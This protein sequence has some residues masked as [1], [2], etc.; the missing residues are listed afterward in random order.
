MS[1]QRSCAPKHFTQRPCT[2]K[3]WTPNSFTQAFGPKPFYTKPCGPKRFT[4][5]LQWTT[6]ARRRAIS[7]R[8]VCSGL[9]K[10]YKACTPAPPHCAR[11][12]QSDPPGS[13][14]GKGRISRPPPQKS[15]TLTKC[16]LA[17]WVGGQSMGWARAAWQSLGWASA[18][19]QSL[20]WQ[21][22]GWASACP[23][24]ALPNSAC[25]TQ[26]LPRSAFPTQALPTYPKWSAPRTLI[27]GRKVVS[28]PNSEKH[29]KT[30][31][32]RPGRYH[33]PPARGS[34]SGRGTNRK[35]DEDKP[36]SRTSVMLL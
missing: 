29:A 28:N 6:T 10:P 34:Y 18:A 19:W 21:A 17:F 5:N 26:A 30:S 31:C 8:F 1:T 14:F 2:Q 15:T 13:Y 12:P 3:L 35:R 27:L 16:G 11:L 22:L 33:R 23:T 32:L 25:L 20:Y 4:P 7:K 9:F 36:V 24:Q